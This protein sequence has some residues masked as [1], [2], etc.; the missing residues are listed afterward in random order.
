MSTRAPRQY[1]L[2]I[3]LPTLNA[4]NLCGPDLPLQLNF[5]P[6]NNEKTG[7]GTGWSLKLTRFTVSSG[8][9][10]LHSGER[11]KV[12]NNGPG[13]AA[14]IAERKLES[15]HF[16]DISE[17]EQKRFRIAHKS[18]LTEIL[19]PRDANYDWAVP[20]RVLAPSGHGINLHYAPDKTTPHL[21][22][23]SDDSKRVLLRIDYTGNA[24]V[25][26]DI[27]PGTEAHARFTL[28]LQ[29]GHLTSVSLPG[30]DKAA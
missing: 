26:I 27:N 30:P 8:M 13:E 9:L 10:N 21:T 29:G 2:S 22:S 28:G 3:D 18:G 6:M 15:F 25:L 12:D 11:F 14:V 4:N 23:I 5:N 19:E 20:V 16:S 1:A 7:F 17:G 24:E